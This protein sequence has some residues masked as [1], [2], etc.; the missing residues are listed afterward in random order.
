MTTKMQVSGGSANCPHNWLGNYCGLCGA[1]RTEE[2][3]NNNQGLIDGLMALADFLDQRPTFP[4]VTPPTFFSFIGY[5]EQLVKVVREQ[6]LG[7]VEKTWLDSFF[8]LKKLF[9]EVELRVTIDR[10][11]V[12]EK[13]ETITQVEEPVMVPT[14]E[15]RLVDKKT[16]QWVCKDSIL[17]GA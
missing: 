16:V 13:V 4:R 11:Q 6:N 3:Q 2:E 12:C 8:Q 10:E 1:C 5:K 17:G 9:G 7:E 14:G 15:K